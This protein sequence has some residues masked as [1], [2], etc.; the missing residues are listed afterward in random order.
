MGKQNGKK[1]FERILREFR[2]SPRKGDEIS[3]VSVNF[4]KRS[5]CQELKFFFSSIREK[6][7][8]YVCET[9]GGD[10]TK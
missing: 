8:V 5:I 6:W 10:W 2:K 9:Y 1:M 7:N 3:S 4:S